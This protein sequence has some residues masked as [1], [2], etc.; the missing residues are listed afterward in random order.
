MMRTPAV[1]KSWHDQA[2]A[3][4]I[5]LCPIVELEMIFGVRSSREYQE[6]SRLFDEMFCWTFIPDRVYDRAAQIQQLLL[7][8]GRHRCASPVDLLVAA[9]AE[10]RNLTVSHYDRDVATIAAVTGQP[11]QWLAAPGSLN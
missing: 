7:G 5:H 10:L 3:K 6:L 1:R 4:I 11:A 8:S 9:T 2:K